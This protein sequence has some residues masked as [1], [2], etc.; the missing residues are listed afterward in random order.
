MVHKTA[1][2]QPPHPPC[3]LRVTQNPCPPR[4]LECLIPLRPFERLRACPPLH[5]NIP[6]RLSY[7]RH[8]LHLA[9]SPKMIRSTT[10]QSCSTVTGRRRATSMGNLAP[11][12]HTLPKGWVCQINL[13]AGPVPWRVE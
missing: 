12:P 2:V 10:R 9:D 1:H 13:V 3:P 7:P 11:A 5:E 6:P 8:L 4:F